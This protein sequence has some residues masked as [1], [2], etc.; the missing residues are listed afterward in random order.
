[1]T[2]ERRKSLRE[3]FQSHWCLNEANE[4]F[5]EIDRLQSEK[6]RVQEILVDLKE[7]VLE[8]TSEFN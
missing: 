1:M 6:Q 4:L 2:D 8:S 5:D 3:F 7:W